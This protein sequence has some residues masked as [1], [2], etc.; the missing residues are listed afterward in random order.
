MPATNGTS[1]TYAKRCGVIPQSAWLEVKVRL[2]QLLKPVA[3]LV[4]A[5]ARRRAEKSR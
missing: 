4:D 3:L 5:L 1:T 2:I